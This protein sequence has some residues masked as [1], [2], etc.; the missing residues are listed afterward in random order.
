MDQTEY[1]E[2]YEELRDKYDKVSKKASKLKY[3]KLEMQTKKHR[4]EEFIET[5]KQSS[6][7]LTDFDE[8]LWYALIEK[9]P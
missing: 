2:Q 9:L 5:L 4:A 3:L 1:N 8:R 7:L 6:E